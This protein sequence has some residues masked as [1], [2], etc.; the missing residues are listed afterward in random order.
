VEWKFDPNLAKSWE[1]GLIFEVLRAS[2]RSFEDESSDNRPDCSKI[3]QVY[4]EIHWIIQQMLLKTAVIVYSLNPETSKILLLQPQNPFWV[5]DQQETKKHNSKPRKSKIQQKFTKPEREN[6][7]LW[8]LFVFPGELKSQVS[9]FFCLSA[10]FLPHPTKSQKYLNFRRNWVVAK[11]RNPSPELFTAVIL[12]LSRPSHHTF[13][14]SSSSPK[15]NI[16]EYFTAPSIMTWR[17]QWNE[18]GC[19]C[20]PR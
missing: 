18:Y 11:G 17:C 19:R 14:G 2:L 1:S 10:T 16:G 7:K 20:E 13:L 8:S 5:A 9:L 6:S 12:S 3:L 15:A 4:L